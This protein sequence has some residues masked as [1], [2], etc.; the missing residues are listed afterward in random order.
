VWNITGP[1]NATIC[2]HTPFYCSE[3]NLDM[4]Y[5]NSI[6]QN[7]RTWF[8]SVE[9]NPFYSPFIRFIEELNADPNPPDVHSISY[10][11]SENMVNPTLMKYFNGELCKLAIRGITIIVSSGDYG[12]PGLEGCGLTKDDAKICTLNP[13]FPANCPYVTSVGATMGPECGKNEMAAYY[14]YSAITT[15]GG[16]SNVFSRP[17]WQ[18]NAVK[19]FLKGE[20]EKDYFNVYGRGY[21]DVS[22]LG[23]N[24]EIYING[25]V[26]YVSGTSASAPVFAS[27]ISLA[28]SIRKSE[29]K[30]KLGF[31]NPLLYSKQ[32][33]NSFN[34]ITEGCN[35]CC[36][37]NYDHCCEVGWH[38][39]TGW[40]PVTGLGSLDIK[41][42]FRNRNR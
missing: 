4:Q 22:V 20:Q 5:I 36:T 32:L 14:P 10:A 30:P 19:K 9:Y 3:G 34:D 42:I 39:T 15:G 25:E 11:N 28:N 29:G 37:V 27:I 2:E 35:K 26:A 31:L 23:N 13:F 6:A 21:P 41:K 40:D 7:A 17:S 38:A 24:Y 18:K 12:A 8:W 33:E 1:N 16:F